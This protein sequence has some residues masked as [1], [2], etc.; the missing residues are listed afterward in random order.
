MASP[1]LHPEPRPTPASSVAPVAYNS[2]GQA[3]RAPGE[4][5]SEN[6]K[7]QEGHTVEGKFRLD[8]K[9]GESDHSI[10]FLT[11]RAQEPKKAAIKLIPAA[12]AENQILH[13][14]LDTKLP[15]PHL[16]RIFESG[17][18]ELN[19]HSLLYVVMEFAEEDL[20][21][22]L[23]HRPL[24]SAEARVMVLP[25]LDVL[26]YL[27]NK[28][29]VHGRLKPGNILAIAD[30]VKVSSDS[31]SAISEG[32]GAP[33]AN[34]PPEAKIGKISP[35]TDVWAL[36]MTLAEVLTLQKPT[37]DATKRQEPV[38][39]NGLDESFRIVI[40]NCLK[41]DDASRWTVGE[42]KSLLQP[43]KVPAMPVTR[44]RKNSPWFYI[45]PVLI[46]LLFGFIFSRVR[47]SKPGN[48]QADV[49]TAPQEKPTA[50]QPN[51]KIADPNAVAPSVKP[52]AAKV[53]VSVPPQ[54]KPATTQAT[55][56]IVQQIL[57]DVPASARRT[58]TG[59][60]RVGVKVSVGA[61]GNVTNTNL[62]SPSRSSYFNR[63][64]L[65]AAEK[66]KF[67]PAP[68]E[69]MIHFIFTS[70]DTTATPAQVKQ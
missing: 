9:L 69:W 57:P 16:L 8:Q 41:L 49:Q 25:V 10:V 7:P 34:D 4:H 36:G 66:W 27:H 12:N 15:H 68:G 52:P 23:P 40:R 30:E 56:A 18:C 1:H 63:L 48:I 38:L 39:P 2:A 35:A 65:Q 46:L 60:I 19:G 33:S 20:S 43:D 64:A 50:A 14:K 32:V 37:W 59:K 51:R 55:G 24:T 54:A 29:F 67:S 5:V 26:S 22:V 17:K 70:S 28:G 13:W 21:Q 3:G 44:G 47:F 58:I 53:A 62:D 45:I 61:D 6:W 42:I 11:E 31:I